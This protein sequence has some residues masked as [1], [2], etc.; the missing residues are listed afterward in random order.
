MAQASK[1]SVNH[2]AVRA[3]GAAIKLILPLASL[4]LLPVLLLC[5]GTAQAQNYPSKPIH[6]LVGPGPDILARIIGVKLTEMLGQPVIV[7]QRPA[8]GGIIAGD[9]VAKSAPDGYTALLSTGSFTINSVFH[10][11]MPYDLKRDLKPVSLMATLPFVLVVNNSL[12]IKNLKD[13]VALARAKPGTLNYASSGNG[14]PAHFAGEMLRQM[15]KIDIVHVPYNGAAPG[16]IDVIGDRVQM[17][18]APAPSVL[19][20]VKSGKLRA[21]AVSSPKRYRGLP[22]VPTV[23]EQG[24]P[25]FSIVGWNGLHVPAKTP[26]EIIDKLSAAVAKIIQMPDVQASIETNGFEPVGSTNK[27]F[28]AFVEQ[29]IARAAV[30]I[31]AGNIRQE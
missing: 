27:E 17:M 31:K 15:A 30:V 7:D 8:A 1:S 3:T 23:A 24:Y 12:P 6:I 28:G 13:L 5:T 2:V 18:F 9:T 14:T 29:D 26:P 4:L 19:Q 20:L 22:D 16:V 11:D 21:I 10:L 25:D